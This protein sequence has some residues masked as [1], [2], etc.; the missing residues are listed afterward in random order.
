[1]T[2]HQNATTPIQPRPPVRH[3]R[4]IQPLR[5]LR[6]IHPAPPAFEERGFGGSA[7]EDGTGRGGG[8]ETNPRPQTEAEV[9]S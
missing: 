9:P 6:P 1:M 3:L 2:P 8:G 4:P 5:L 7:P